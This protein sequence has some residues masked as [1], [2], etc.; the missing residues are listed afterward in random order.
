MSL[1]QSPNPFPL[2]AHCSADQWDCGHL[3]AVQH[4]CSHPF[5]AQASWVTSARRARCCSGS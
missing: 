2:S 5:P 4:P 1:T 3:P